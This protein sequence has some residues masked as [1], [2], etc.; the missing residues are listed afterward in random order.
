MKKTIIMAL[1]LVC[2][3]TFQVL[4]LSGA[5]KQPGEEK[6]KK[7]DM[8]LKEGKI[9]D[10]IQLLNAILEGSKNCAGAY[11]RLAYAYMALGRGDDAA[12]YAARAVQLDPGLSVSYNI[13]GMAEERKGN[14][15]AACDYYQKAVKND[16]RYAKA[17]NNLGNMYLKSSDFKKAEITY[18]AAISMDP[19]L[20]MAHNN[21]A[22]VL[23]LQGKAA[24]AGREYEKALQIDPGLQMAKNN[25]TRLQEKQASP[26]ASEKEKEIARAICYYETPEGYTLVKASMPQGGGRL[27]LFEYHFFQTIILRE[28]PP[29]NKIN[30]ALFAQMIVTYKQE[31]ITLLEGLMDIKNMKIAGQGYVEVDGRKVLY[32]TTAFDYDGSPVDGLFSLISSPGGKRSVLI[33]A[34]APRGLYQRGATEAFLKKMRFE[35]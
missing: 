20:A 16:P 17:F 30:E 10:S 19:K 32:I 15:A 8:L 25:L 21:L 35:K 7:A 24:E 6:L 11:D 13:L 1:V 34:I 9:E 18:R 2:F 5:E 26:G 28:L 33:M 27:A 14:N 22:F 29:D 3:F 23:E 4:P 31:L 12:R